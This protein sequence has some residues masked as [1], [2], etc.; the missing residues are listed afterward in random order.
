[1]W[2]AGLGSVADRPGADIENHGCGLQLPRPSVCLRI[3]AIQST[4][5]QGSG[6][7]SRFATDRILRILRNEGVLADIRP[8]SGKRPA[9]L[10]HTQLLRIAEGRFGS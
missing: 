5:L 7:H 9:F 4:N 3:G 8:A 2:H 10:A 6:L 1:M